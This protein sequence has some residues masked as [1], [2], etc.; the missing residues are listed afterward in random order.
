M[1]R[2]H[3]IAMEKAMKK[4]PILFKASAIL[5]Y[6]DCFGQPN[7]GAIIGSSRLG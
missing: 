4:H 3:L 5:S 6:L 1:I 7:F 2:Y